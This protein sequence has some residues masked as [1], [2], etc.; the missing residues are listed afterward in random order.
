MTQKLQKLEDKVF[1]LS[2]PIKSNAVQASMT[3]AMYSAFKGDYLRISNDKYILKLLQPYGPSKIEFF[4]F[5]D[6]YSIFETLNVCTFFAGESR[7]VFS[8]Y[9][10]KINTK[11]KIDRRILIITEKAMYQCLPN[12][13]RTCRR[14]LLAINFL[15]ASM[16]AF[17]SDLVALH[18]TSGYGLH[19]RLSKCID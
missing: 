6:C 1:A 15:Q 5:F 4:H 19:Q 10:E 8:D 7:V 13:E 14:R 3:R 18:H 17:A 11:G 2:K 9:V 16:S 12:K